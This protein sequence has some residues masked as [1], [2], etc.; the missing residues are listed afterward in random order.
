M[1]A[2]SKVW[3]SL[4][5][6][7]LV[8][9]RQLCLPRKESKKRLRFF[10]YREEHVL[11]DIK[12]DFFVWASVK[13]DSSFR[14][15]V[16]EEYHFRYIDSF[17]ANTQSV[18]RYMAL[19]KRLSPSV[20]VMLSIAEICLTVWEYLRQVSLH[21]Y[22]SLCTIFCYCFTSTWILKVDHSQAYRKEHFCKLKSHLQWKKGSLV[23]L[24]HVQ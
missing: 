2:A 1:I 20:R 7:L 15:N 9:N 16:D 5:T 13:Q 24:K 12:I 14:R 18:P 6:V 21:L 8:L 11:F 4:D 19:T 23:G 10:P 17:P 3:L 22:G